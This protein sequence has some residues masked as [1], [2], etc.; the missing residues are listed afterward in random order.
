MCPT[1]VPGLAARPKKG[2]RG[3]LGRIWTTDGSNASLSSKNLLAE[4]GLLGDQRVGTATEDSTAERSSLSSFPRRGAHPRA[5]AS[6]TLETESAARRDA[7]RRDAY[8]RRLLLAADV[9]AAGLA[10]VVAVQVLGLKDV[11]R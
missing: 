4:S 2:S 5:A 9:L 7:R 1:L 8:F 6:S 3:S 11:L 10:L